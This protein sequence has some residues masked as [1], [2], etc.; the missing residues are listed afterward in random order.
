MIKKISKQ[1]LI[2]GLPLCLIILIIESLINWQFSFFYSLAFIIGLFTGLLNLYITNRGLKPLEY[3]AVSK[4]KLF[5]SLLHIL[6]F[7]I[8]GLVLYFSTLFFGL[9]SAFACAFGMLFNKIVIYYIYLI[10]VPRED[11]K[12]LVDKLDLPKS[13]IEKLKYNDFFKI[14]DITEVD[15]K[16]LREFLTEQEV[17]S[18]IKSLK[19]Y[20][21][22]IKGELEAIIENDEN[23]DV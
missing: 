2:F 3:N 6:K 20:E 10:K 22:F 8:Y 12:R 11:K 23:V 4:P 7:L 14:M 9:Y 5:Y 17:D 16:R 19:K 15:R 18:V 21:L 13:I 1:T